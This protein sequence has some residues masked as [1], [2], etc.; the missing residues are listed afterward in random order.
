LLDTRTFA[1]PVRKNALVGVDPPEH[2]KQRAVLS[3][4][5]SPVA[6]R[7]LAADYDAAAE[8]IVTQALERSRFDMVDD[9]IRPFTVTVLADAV[10]IPGE[11]REHLS[12]L[13]EMILTSVGPINQRYQD[14]VAHVVQAGSLQ[15]S[16]NV[17]RRESLAPTG[18][19]ADIYAAVDSGE[20]DAQ[21]AALLVSLFLFGGIDTT[22][23]ALANGIK[24]FLDHPD[25]WALMSCDPSCAKDAFEEAS[26]KSLP[27]E[28]TPKA[29]AA[30]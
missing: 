11:G 1:A 20:I 21:E 2:T 24:N 16:E 27:V 19:G 5:L 26:W 6:T 18:F 14:A 8:R 4:I 10:G 12:I 15:W 7:K 3:R 17:S 29:G 23:T 25:Q 13:G 30:V 9:V 22:I 28:V